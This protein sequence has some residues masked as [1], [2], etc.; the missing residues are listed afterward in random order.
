MKP[1]LSRLVLFLLLTLR[2][3][4]VGMLMCGLG[5]L[6]GARRVFF[7]LCMIPLTV[8]FSSRTVG[9][10]CMFMMFGSFVVFI[11]GHCQS[12]FVNSLGI[13]ANL[14]II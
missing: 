4:F 11:S 7:T 2:M 3:R 14:H 10:G 12:P 6:F 5:M 13:I 9:L 1:G 8:V